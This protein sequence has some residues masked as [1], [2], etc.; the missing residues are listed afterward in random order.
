MKMMDQI[1]NTILA[2]RQ[3]YDPNN[4]TSEDRL[5]R[6][7]K[8]KELKSLLGFYIERAYRYKYISENA[9]NTY[10]DFIQKLDEGFSLVILLNSSIV[11]LT[12]FLTYS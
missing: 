6:D 3:H 5:D 12:A 4:Y 2:L 8:N 10:W 11:L 1:N 7:I 9:Y